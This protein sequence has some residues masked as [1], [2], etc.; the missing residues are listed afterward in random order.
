VIKNTSTENPLKVGK[1]LNT[2]VSF[3]N[4]AFSTSGTSDQIPKPT[5]LPL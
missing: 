5:A 4:N 1:I 2:R 3:D